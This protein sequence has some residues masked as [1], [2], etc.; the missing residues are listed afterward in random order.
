MKIDII[1]KFRISGM[2]QKK[3]AYSVNVRLRDIF[4]LTAIALIMNTWLATQTHAATFRLEDGEVCD[5]SLNGRIEAGDAQ[6]LERFLSDTSYTPNTQTR[7]LRIPLRS[8]G[9]KLC[10]NSPGGSLVEA[11]EIAEI[12]YSGYPTRIRAGEQCLSACAWIFML[13]RRHQ[14]DDFFSTDRSMSV[15]ADLGFHAPSLPIS[16]REYSNQELARAMNVMNAAFAEI[17]KLAKGENPREQGIDY[18]LIQFAMATPSDRFF[19]V[20]R[21]GQALR[22]QI[23]ISDTAYF[24][25]SRYVTRAAEYNACDNAQRAFLYYED[26]LFSD[27]RFGWGARFR[28]T[29]TSQISREINQ[30]DFTL[31]ESG[32][33]I[34]AC[35]GRLRIFQPDYTNNE[36]R[37]CHIYSQSIVGCLYSPIALFPGDTR[38]TTLGGEEGSRLYAELTTTVAPQ[39]AATTCHLD[40]S[41]ARIANVNEYTN[42]RSRA[43]L[44]HPVIARVP[45]QA[46]VTQP[47]PGRYLATERCLQICQGDNQRAIQQCIDNNEVWIVATHNNRTGFL[48]RKFLEAVQ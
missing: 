39:P 25:P 7:P 8:S 28:N 4:F 14:G 17:L 33:D 30:T 13:G 34:T 37:V 44:G 32:Y 18:D 6:A 2:I 27:S 40:G 46:T 5:F 31:T 35:E 43:G 45:L 26:N 24:D 38:L 10:L 48:S 36:Y 47:N 15:Y 9:A 23:E 3:H 29:P 22:W 12:V 1:G 16:E 20:E 11:A 19:Y 21:V 41:Q 42:L